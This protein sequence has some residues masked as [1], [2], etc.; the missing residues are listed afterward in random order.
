MPPLLIHP[1]DVTNLSYDRYPVIVPY[2]KTISTLQTMLLAFLKI[3][4]LILVE[5]VLHKKIKVRVHVPLNNVR[6][7]FKAT[8]NNT[9]QTSNLHT[10]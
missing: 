7:Y 9:L 3:N 2:N 4:L 6:L 10:P 8:E 1:T 5:H